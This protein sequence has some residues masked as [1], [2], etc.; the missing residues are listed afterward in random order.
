MFATAREMPVPIRLVSDRVR[1]T[2]T[3]L[4]TGSTA[5][6]ARLGVSDRNGFYT[7][8]ELRNRL[9]IST[10]VFWQY[11]PLGEAALEELRD[12]GIR[13][14]ELLE[15]PEQFD[16]ANP[17]SMRYVAQ[18]CRACGIEVVAYHAQRT[19]LADLDTEA[20]RRAEVD[21]CRRQID[22]MLELGGHV[23]GSHAGAADRTIVQCYKELARHVE[24]TR[25]VITVENFAAEGRGIE[26]RVAF[27]EEVSHPQVGMI[28]D[29]GHVRDRAGA[30]PMC[31][32]GG[33]SRVIGMCGSRIRHLHLHGFKG[34]VGHFPPLVVG[35]D[36]EWVELFRM[37][38]A[39]GYAGPINFEP[40][41][42]PKHAN[43]VQATAAV[44]ERIVQMEAQ[45]PQRAAPA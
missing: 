20:K 42:E 29:I 35:D 13:Q 15:S 22:T 28:L 43:A 17:R 1:P 7:V 26:D 4:R 2:R 32:P 16:M 37:L 23:W 40:C 19:D 8:E 3:S 31:V 12:H 36:I 41:G 24:G 18:T 30:N 21:R 11:R 10:S 5:E 25:A 14:I 44:P 33:P 6:K 38:W 39:I 45:T 27:L 9:S 34:G